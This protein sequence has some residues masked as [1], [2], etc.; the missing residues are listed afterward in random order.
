MALE[1][2]LVHTGLCI[3]KVRPTQLFSLFVTNQRQHVWYSEICK[4]REH[5]IGTPECRVHYI[6]EISCLILTA[7]H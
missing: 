2:Y 5:I 4:V 3:C 6:P 7:E 1:S